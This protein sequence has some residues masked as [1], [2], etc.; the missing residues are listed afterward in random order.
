MKIQA[1][2]KGA[3]ERLGVTSRV[4]NVTAAEEKKVLRVIEISGVIIR[5]YEVRLIGKYLRIERVCR[6]INKTVITI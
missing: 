2:N 5:N 6:W 4:P 3:T 1:Y